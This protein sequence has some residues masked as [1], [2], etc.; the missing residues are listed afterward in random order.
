MSERTGILFIA[1]LLMAA[2]VH[3]PEPFKRQTYVLAPKESV[4]I[5]QLSLSITNEGCGRQ[6]EGEAEKPYCGLIIR[7]RDSTIRAGQ[8]FKPIYI[9]NIRIEIN[10]MNPWGIA[11]DSIPPGGCLLTVTKLEDNSR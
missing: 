4:S 1:L 2:C 7:Y 9:R 10:Q 5:P 8:N 6:W 11:E 3:H